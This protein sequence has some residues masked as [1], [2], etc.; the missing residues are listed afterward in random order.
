MKKIAILGAVLV[1]CGLVFI[2]SATETKAAKAP[3]K[4]G[5]VIDITGPASSLGEP[6]KLTL[7]MLVAD[8][9]A[10]GGV[11]GRKIELIIYDNEGDE[12]KSLIKAKKL[13]TEDKVLA[14]IGTSQSGTTLA[15]VPTVME[16][17]IPLVSCAASWK[18]IKDPKTMETRKWI[19]KTP[20]SDSLAVEKIFDYCVKQGWTKVAVITVSNGYGDSGREV[21][22][23]MAPD[24]KIDVVADERFGQD[25][26]DMTA[27]LTKIK[28]TDAQAVI[29][30]SIQ[31]APAI[32]ARN[33][34]DLGMTQQLIMSHGVAN[35]TFID[36]AGDAAN[37]IILPSGRLIVAEQLPDTDKF[38]KALVDYKTKFETKY[39]KPISTFG[40]HAYDAFEILVRALKKSGANP[41]PAKIRDQ[42]EKT[43]GYVGTAGIF[44]MSP[45]D[46]EGLTREA[47]V[48]V[49]IENGKW[50]LSK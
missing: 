5:A 43:R 9:N 37:G 28:G 23:K 21:L 33:F 19:F 12:A 31:K 24:F 13:I 40:G 42:I 14:M 34:K 50:V 41:T 4:I 17:Q 1:V 36:L 15:I 29:C 6:E 44:N 30:W 47:F 7:E 45:T 3:L 16:A 32:V 18:I 20:Q 48:M 22:K 10:K 38:K 39:N 25:D 46:H 11:N 8:L 49:K 27:Q 35:R 2:S 26:T